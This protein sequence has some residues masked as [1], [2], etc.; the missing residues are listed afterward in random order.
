MRK[1][2]PLAGFSFDIERLEQR[3]LLAVTVGVDLNAPNQTIRGIGANVTKNARNPDPNGPIKDSQTVV[4]LQNYELGMVRVAINLKTWEPANDNNDPNV[5]R[6]PGFP[7]FGGIK[8][9][10]EFM[11]E[12]TQKGIP[13]IATL[14]DLPNWMV[15]NPEAVQKRELKVGFETELAESISHWLN[16]AR[17]Q[18]G[19]KIDF[20]SINEGNGGYNA[21]FN[22]LIF[23]NFL[24]KAGP[25]MAGKGLGYVKWF[26]GDDGVGTLNAHTKPLLEN[27]EIRQYLG[28]VA[29]HSWSF[30]FINDANLEQWYVQANRYGKEVWVTEFGTSEFGADI[31]NFQ[32]W[33]RA[34]DTANS[35][36]RALTVTRANVVLWWQFANDFPFFNSQNQPLPLFHTTK[37]FFDHVKPGSQMVKTTPNNSGSIKTLASKDVG[38]NK[39]FAQVLNSASAGTAGNTVTLSGLPNQPMT[40]TRSTEAAQG[41]IVGTFTPVNGRLTFSSPADSVIYVTGKLNSGGVS[42][43]PTAAISAPVTTLQYT[44][45]GTVN[46]SGTASD[47]EDGLLAAGKFNWTITPVRDGIFGAAQTFAGVKSGTFTVPAGFQRSVD[48]RY[49]IELKVTDSSGLTNTKS[50]EIRPKIIN[51]TVTANVPGVSPGLNGLWESLTTPIPVV[52]GVQNLFAPSPQL[53]DGRI[54]KFSSWSIGGAATQ[55]V[56][57]STNAS[58]IAN[59]VEVTDGSAGAFAGTSDDSYVRDGDGGDVNYGQATELQAKISNDAGKTRYAYLRFDLTTPQTNTAKLRVFGNLSGAGDLVPTYAYGVNPGWNENTITFN[60]RPQFIGNPIA[61][62]TVADTLGRW[63]EF[64]VTTYVKLARL[65]GATAVSFALTQIG[66]SS[67]F[68]GF[69]S[70]EACLLYTSPSPRD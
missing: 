50:I 26:F 66:N 4:Q 36:W 44:A 58:Y 47:A 39:F 28:P 20:I 69:A 54:Y 14:L 1:T 40:I 62:Q 46:F 10:F 48:Q 63:Y 5:V 31:T 43:A 57:T 41:A 8:Q 55:S 60:N 7:D 29:Y 65:G 9:N 30:R 52:A 11:R 2:S 37:P 21:R 27:P 13:V 53:V 67:P 18:Y 51:V 3:Q 33:T 25:F 56:T 12:Q 42:Q 23:T 17:Q 45:G 16:Y 6:P 35:W 64:D 34:R 22:Q 59:F 15:S 61:A 68:A 19:V 24:K 32:T 70:S 49:V 38:R